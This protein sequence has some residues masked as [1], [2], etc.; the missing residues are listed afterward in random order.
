MKN[1]KILFSCVLL[2]TGIFAFAQTDENA[3]QAQVSQMVSDW[4]T[5]KFVSANSIHR[6]VSTAET[7]ECRQVMIF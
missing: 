4:N 6:M 2:I 1:F 5:H 7:T 3:I